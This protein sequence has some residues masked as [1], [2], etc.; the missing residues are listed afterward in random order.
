MC[1]CVRES[2]FVCMCVFV[3]GREGGSNGGRKDEMEGEGDREGGSVQREREGERKGERSKV[4]RRVLRQ[5]VKLLVPAKDRE[6]CLENVRIF[7]A[8]LSCYG[9]PLIQQHNRCGQWPWV[10]EHPL[11]QSLYQILLRTPLSH[12]SNL[13]QWK[14]SV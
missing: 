4:S 12:N 7:F 13:K 14:R 11:Q 10:N 1:A 2:F 5:M 9:T 8:R 3:E 6:S